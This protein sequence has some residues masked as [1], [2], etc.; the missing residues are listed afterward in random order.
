MAINNIVLDF[1]GTCTQ[2]PVIYEGYLTQYLAELNKR[3]FSQKPVTADEWRDAQQLV[4][5]NSPKAPWTIGFSPSAPAAADP[6]IMAYESAK[7]IIRQRIPVGIKD[8]PFEAHRDAD[9]ANPAPWRMEAREIIEELL[10]K[11][12]NVYFI[13]NSSSKKITQRLLELLELSTLPKGIKVESDAAKFYISEL[14]WD[15]ALP[16][17]TKLHFENLPATVVTSDI[18]RPVHLRRGFYFEAICKVFNNNL[19]DLG[20]TVFCGDIWEMDLAMPYALGANIHL[21]D[22]SAP[23]NTYEFEY[24]ALVNSGDRAK[25]SEDL[26]GLLNWVNCN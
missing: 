5:N 20:S 8:P 17:E 19:D 12:I 7:Y 11:N 21:I 25:K 9:E 3:V 15:T 14:M 24:N 4:S 2:I 26:K 22:R 13:S 16:N 10:K 6:Y 18:G 23:F 1:D